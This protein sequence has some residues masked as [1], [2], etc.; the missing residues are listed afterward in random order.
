MGGVVR[1]TRRSK[2]KEVA[3]AACPSGVVPA[4]PGCWMPGSSRSG[5][6]GIHNGPFMDEETET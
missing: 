5:L 3:C 6:L 1:K 4:G 2:Q